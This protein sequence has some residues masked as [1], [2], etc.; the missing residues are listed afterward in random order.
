MI[1]EIQGMDMMDAAT[2]GVAAGGTTAT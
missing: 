1:G 2:I